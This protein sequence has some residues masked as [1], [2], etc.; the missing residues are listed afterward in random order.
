M[1]LPEELIKEFI[2]CGSIQED[3]SFMENVQNEAYNQ[4]IRDVV[5]TM[6]NQETL[7]LAKEVILKLLKK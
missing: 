5:E 2:H 1:R 4:A 3:L 7:K 6:D